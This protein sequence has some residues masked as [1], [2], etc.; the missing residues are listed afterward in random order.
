[1]DVLADDEV[2]HGICPS[3]A[4]SQYRDFGLAL[5]TYLK[6]NQLVRSS[7]PLAS[8][9]SSRLLPHFSYANQ[10]RVQ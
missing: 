8:N 9:S 7:C 2:Q 5:V 6:L 10:P 3:P 4:S 1:M